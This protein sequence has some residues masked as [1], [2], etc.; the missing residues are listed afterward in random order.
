MWSESQTRWGWKQS[1]VD[2]L[3]DT[4]RAGEIAD[5]PAKKLERNT[6]SGDLMIDV[7]RA[8]LVDIVRSTV[9]PYKP[10]RDQH[11]L[12]GIPY[13]QQSNAVNLASVFSARPG[14]DGA[15]P[16]SR[17]RNGR[18]SRPAP[19]T[20][21]ESQLAGP[22]C[23]IFVGAGSTPMTARTVGRPV[24]WRRPGY[25]GDAGRS[26]A[27]AAVVARRG[28]SGLRSDCATWLK[29]RRREPVVTP[30]SGGM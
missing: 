8:D 2:R 4:P 6:A 30:S 18:G 23:E 14:G 22:R 10:L 12:P 17:D 25:G 13:P 16:P 20:R 29:D 3:G 19:T 5:L 11:L 21:Y 26:G 1:L 24:A 9:A 7:G 15:G 27:R 28:G